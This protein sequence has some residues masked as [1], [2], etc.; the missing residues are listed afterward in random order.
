MKKNLLVLSVLLLSLTGQAQFLQNNSVVW[1]P[2]PQDPRVKFT[3]YTKGIMVGGVEQAELLITNISSDKLHIKIQYTVSDYCGNVK[4]F[5]K[6]EV[7][8]A[9]KESKSSGAF[10]TGIDFDTDCKDK[11]KYSDNISSKVN[12]V[13]V[14]IQSIEDLTAK[15]LAEQRKKEEEDKLAALKKGSYTENVSKAED[16]EQKKDYKSALKYYTAALGTGVDDSKMKNAISNATN[17]IQ[18]IKQEEE[19]ALRQIEL[20][21]KK[22]RQKLEEKTIESAKAAERKLQE[23]AEAIEEENEKKIRQAASDLEG[24][25]KQRTKDLLK[26]RQTKMKLEEERIIKEKKEYKEKE[27]KT[28]R[29]KDLDLIASVKTK[30]SYDPIQYNYWKDLGDKYYDEGMH[31]DPYSALKLESKWWDRN[32]YMK[33]FKEDLNEPRRKEAWDN[34]LSLLYDV[35]ASFNI[36]KSYYISAVEYTDLDSYQYKNLM[37]RIESMNDMID[38]QK[39]MIERSQQIEQEREK[40]FYQA[41]E[42]MKAAV[43]SGRQSKAYLLYSARTQGATYDEWNSDPKVNQA[44]RERKDFEKRD[45]QAEK[46]LRKDEVI[47]ALGTE[48]VTTMMFDG[49][50]TSVAI[51]KNDVAINVFINTGF[52][53]Y[54]VVANDIPRAGF[55]SRTLIETLNVIPFEAGAIL[56]L[57]RG[58]VW[59]LGIAGDASYG[60]LPFKGFANNLFTYGA[61]LK[62]DVGT[63]RVKL[64]FEADTH[65]RSGNYNYDRDVFLADAGNNQFQQATGL[66]QEGTFNYGVLKV[67]GGL[68]IDLADKEDDAYIRL[69]VFA[70]KP[71]F[72]TD[73][74]IKKPFLTFNGQA[75]IRYG[76]LIGFEYGQ[77]YPAAGTANNV[78]TTYKDRA[79]FRAR[80]GKIWTLGKIHW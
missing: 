71:S 51:G 18:Q 14:Y 66:I 58:K 38:F 15:E 39:E 72:V 22:D 6:D 74:N 25:E 50:K 73:F 32:P 10:Y 33:S 45:E 4:E 29:D 47:T 7:L 54:P 52:S 53:G 41:K 21:E 57:H 34:C 19:E 31:T 30:M 17:K 65:K 28:R 2:Y 12:Y 78:I 5:L 70:E 37:G 42:A 36:A 55:K 49:D 60:V 13:S 75:V 63:K 80:V 26:E 16:A 35:Q 61:N 1:H 56:W 43:K 9:N 24:E 67:G 64:A 23:S 62:L 68:H 27:Q 79:F 20:Q 11:K 69:L 59:N 40:N 46:Q 8:E 48:A 76:G 44:V 77:N 3:F